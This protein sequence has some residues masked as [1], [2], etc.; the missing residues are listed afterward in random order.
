MSALD[1]W[2]TILLGGALT[3]TIRFSFIG[4]LTHHR[5]P[6]WAGHALRLVPVA[7]LSALAAADIAAPQ[8]TSALLGAKLLAALTA[9]I[10][11]AWTRSVGWAVVAGMGVFLAIQAWV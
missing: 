6:A 4:L 10:A 3:F 5:L 8:A 1:I 9:A 7:A 2:L 11:A